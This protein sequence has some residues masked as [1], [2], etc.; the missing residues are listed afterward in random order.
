[1]TINYDDRFFKAVSNSENGEVDGSTIFHYRQTDDLVWGTYQGGQV[2][3][4]TLVAKVLPD[5]SLEM[6]YSH[7]NLN[8]EMMT[9]DCRSTPELLKDGRIRLNEKWQWTCGDCSQGESTV[10]ELLSG[11]LG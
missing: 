11:D 4:G 3:F 2:R 1:M 5:A 6:R 9:G 8:G 10:E 7:V